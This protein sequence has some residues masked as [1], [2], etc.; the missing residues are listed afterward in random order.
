MSQTAITIRVDS[1][2]KKNFDE[3]CED[4]GLNLSSAITIFMKTVVRQ[5]R[6][7]FEIN[8][9]SCDDDHN[10]L[11]NAG[12]LKFSPEELKKIKTKGLETFYSLRDEAKK[13]GLQDMVL[14]EINTEIQKTRNGR[15]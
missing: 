5:K 4:F 15:S 11:Q 2:L 10:P 12:Y 13:N 7:P 8:N 6:I 3:L 1:S 14:E 9:K